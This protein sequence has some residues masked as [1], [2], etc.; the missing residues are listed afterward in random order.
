MVFDLVRDT[1]IAAFRLKDSLVLFGISLEHVQ[2]SKRNI[3]IYIYNI[4][5][6]KVYIYIKIKMKPFLRVR[7]L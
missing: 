4:F 3:Q 2:T 5:Q 1:D 7:K 6:D